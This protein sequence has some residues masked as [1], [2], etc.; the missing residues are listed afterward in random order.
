ML[1]KHGLSNSAP[2][3]TADSAA[4][5]V[6]CCLLPVGV[7]ECQREEEQSTTDPFLWE[8]GRRRREKKLENEAM[9]KCE[10][11]YFNRSLLLVGCREYRYFG[12][13]WKC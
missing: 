2:S 13:F 4:I 3:L 1:K 8:E 9:L 6:C 11:N 10:K 7:E 5:V 12:L